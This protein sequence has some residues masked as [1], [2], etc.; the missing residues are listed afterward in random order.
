MSF[1]ANRGRSSLIRTYNDLVAPISRHRRHHSHFRWPIYHPYNTNRYICDL[2]QNRT[3]AR[4]Y[5]EAT[6]AVPDSRSYNYCDCCRCPASILTVYKPP[7]DYCRC[8]ATLQID[9]EWG[10]TS[11]CDTR[12]DASLRDSYLSMSG[13]D[14]C[15]REV[16]RQ[17]V[18][19]I[20]CPPPT[21]R[22]PAQR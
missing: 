17:T 8:D 19:C 6:R 7:T 5:T 10:L 22:T 16:E 15:H 18:S 21:T 13:S 4:S 20:T 14:P 2:Q 12:T 1:L 9:Q 11:S 3:A